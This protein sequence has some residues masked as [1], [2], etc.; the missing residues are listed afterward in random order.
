MRLLVRTRSD[1]R[2]TLHDGNLESMR[3]GHA[4]KYVPHQPHTDQRQVGQE[5]SQSVGGIGRNG[6]GWQDRQDGR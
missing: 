1:I 2:L 6:E 5:V 3:R 4:T